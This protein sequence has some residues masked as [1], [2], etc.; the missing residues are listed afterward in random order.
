MTAKLGKTVFIPRLLEK[1]NAITHKY[2]GWEVDR[3]I[4]Q[5]RKDGRKAVAIDAIALIESGLNRLCD[6]V[7]GVVA[8]DEERI[9]GLCSGRA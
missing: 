4:E 6:T 5:E 2:V 9:K 1:L 8:P 7:V 3:I